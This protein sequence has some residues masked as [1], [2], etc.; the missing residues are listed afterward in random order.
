MSRRQ[1]LAEEQRAALPEILN[2]LDLDRAKLSV[3]VLASLAQRFHSL[4]YRERTDE[5]T[6]KERLKL[7]LLCLQ[8]LSRQE[9]LDTISKS[10]E[11]IDSVKKLQWVTHSLVHPD[12][13][14]SEK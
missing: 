4:P 8:A 1:T 11:L 10:P 13:S 3:R 2:L 14:G 6:L 12:V 5:A 9:S 7:A